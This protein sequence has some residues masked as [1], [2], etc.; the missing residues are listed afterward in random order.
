M[1]VRFRYSKLGKIRWISHRDGARVW[2]RALRRAGLPIAYTEGFSP[3]PKLSFGLALPTGYESCAEYLDVSLRPQQPIDVAALPERLS[4]VLPSGM[5]TQVAAVLEQPAD[6]LQQVVTS[7]SWRLHVSGLSRAMV[8]ERRTRLLAADHVPYQR[9]RK[10]KIVSDDLRPCVLSL[11]VSGEADGFVE[12]TAELTTQPRAVKP[13]ELIAALGPDLQER[14]GC[15]THQWI[16]RDG[17]RREPL[18][19]PIEATDP[20]PH[21]HMRA[22]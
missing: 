5:A 10:G 17:A 13:T 7:S 3:R 11:F 1:I 12:L 18:E 8:E 22:S 20:A 19:V 2:E 15:R 6:S 16:A 14:P 21:A 4:S 9:E